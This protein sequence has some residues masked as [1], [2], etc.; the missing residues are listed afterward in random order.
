[1]SE[2][3]VEIVRRTYAAANRGDFDSANEH[4]HPEIE[5]H[6]YA[7]SP[8]AGVYRG[9]D[10]V[11]QYNQGLFAQ[12]ESINVELEE[13]IDAGARV[14][15]MSTQYAVPKGGRQ[16]MEVHLAEVW[17]VRDGLL[18][19]RRSYSTREDALEAA[20]LSE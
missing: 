4:L 14:V 12:F 8:E 16:E 7:Q 11:L 13:L 17:S 18:I 3:N 5:F 1:M 15:V 2:E 6:T 19:E 10:A 20:G 9:K